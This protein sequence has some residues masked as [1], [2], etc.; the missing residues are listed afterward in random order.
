MQLTALGF[1]PF[2]MLS[3]MQS[4]RGKLLVQ[5]RFMNGLASGGRVP[6]NFRCPL[7]KYGLTRNM[8]PNTCMLTLSRCCR[9][10]STKPLQLR[11][12]GP[13]RS[14][15]SAPT[16]PARLLLGRCSL[17][18]AQPAAAQ[19]ANHACPLRDDKQLAAVIDDHRIP[20][21]L[22]VVATVDAIVALADIC[23][24]SCT[25]VRLLCCLLLLQWAL[26]T[27]KLCEQEFV[28][29][30]SVQ[31]QPGGFSRVRGCN[32]AI[33][34]PVVAPYAFTLCGAGVH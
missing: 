32:L 14:M 4:S 8:T 11:L 28:I 29:P 9:S 3:Y 30:F 7:S 19:P 16:L 17:Q 22:R 5:R 15:G 13:L 33:N 20:S 24:Q 25:E 26:L 12:M 10:Q 34:V 21:S 2:L 6:R 27:H 18:P 31:S 1:G 23:A